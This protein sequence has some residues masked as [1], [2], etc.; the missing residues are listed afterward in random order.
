MAMTRDLDHLVKTHRIARERRDAGLP[1]WKWRIPIKDLLSADESDEVAIAAG[2]EIAKRLRRGLPGLLDTD[3]SAY[4]DDFDD[5]VYEFEHVAAVEDLNETLDSLY[6]W[7]D[8]NR[9]WLS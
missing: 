8:T 5:I 9:L 1:V 7:A 3:N 6:D 2:T 4:D